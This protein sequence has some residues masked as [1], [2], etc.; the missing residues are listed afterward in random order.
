MTVSSSS[1]SSCKCQKASH[2]RGDFR[3]TNKRKRDGRLFFL[4]R[5]P[6]QVQAWRYVSLSGGL[7]DMEVTQE[8]KQKNKQNTITG[9]SRRLR[10]MPFSRK[11]GSSGGENA[12]SHAS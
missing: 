5:V 10:R 4:C 1:F 2:T 6:I 12:E 8:K 9:A 11:Q 3:G 7:S